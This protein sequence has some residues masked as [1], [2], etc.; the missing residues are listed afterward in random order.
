MVT[1]T[2]CIIMQLG[3]LLFA[4]ALSIFVLIDKYMSLE[5]KLKMDFKL[6]SA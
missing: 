3:T 2:A 5:L 1:Y 6:C 4:F